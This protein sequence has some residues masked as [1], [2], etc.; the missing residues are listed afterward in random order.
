MDRYGRGFGASGHPA[1]TPPAACAEAARTADSAPWPLGERE[2]YVRAALGIGDPW[3]LD[4]VDRALVAQARR[5]WIA[6]PRI[7]AWA[8]LQAG[9]SGCAGGET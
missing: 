6:R 1:S 7:A 2:A 5:E 3:T 9:A 8:A 4:A